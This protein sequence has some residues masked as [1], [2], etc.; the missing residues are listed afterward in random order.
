[1]RCGTGKKRCSSSKKKYEQN[2]RYGWRRLTRRW[3]RMLLLLPISRFRV[4][5]Q[6]AAGRPFSI[7]ER[8]ILKSIF[9]G[10]ATVDDLRH[11]FYVHPR[12][13]LEALVT[14][15]QA[16]WLVV[17]GGEAQGFRLTSAGA[18]A[19][20]SGREPRSRIV[21][22]RYAWVVMERLTGALI[23]EGAVRY[24]QKTEIADLLEFG[25]K[26]SERIVERRLNEAQVDLFLPRARTEVLFRIASIDMKTRQAQ[27]LPVTFD[28]DRNQFDDN[29]PVGWRDRLCPAL[30]EEIAKSS[31]ASE[32]GV[33]GY[34]GPKLSIRER[35][36]R[37]G[38]DVPRLP[39]DKCPALISKTDLLFT[40]LEH[41]NYVRA[42]LAGAT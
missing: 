31:R 14:L 39:D 12:L 10:A 15:T 42:A 9:D 38:D 1:M 34:E 26:I 19:V 6:I 16:G 40:D 37:E 4:E 8:L 11:I 18:E 36:V 25:V 22:A 27:W 35:R 2:A 5:Y 24:L 30:L 13:I 29:L 32:S 20:A 7:F 33:R 3:G 23:N 17:G 21:E 41:A 28:P